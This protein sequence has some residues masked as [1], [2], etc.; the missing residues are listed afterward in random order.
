[1]GLRN[2]VPIFQRVIEHCLQPVGDVASPYV[3]DII[4]GTKPCEGGQEGLLAQHDKDLR[5]VLDVLHEQRLVAD[6]NK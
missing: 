4:I 3:D 5:R 6:K 1:M 2:G